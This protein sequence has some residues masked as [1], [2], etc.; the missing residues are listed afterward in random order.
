MFGHPDAIIF[1]RPFSWQCC[2]LCRPRVFLA[3]NKLGRFATIT[4]PC[5]LCAFE[6]DI[7]AAAA[8]DGGETAGSST[9]AGENGAKWYTVSGTC[10]QPGA[11]CL[12]PCGPCRRIVLQVSDGKDEERRAPVGAIARVVPGCLTSLVSQAS[13]YTISFPQG[14]HEHGLRR[15]SLTAAVMLMNYVF[16]EEK[17]N[18]NDGGGGGGGE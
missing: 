14:Q 12:C 4:N 11:F 1:N 13:S 6:F 2:C 16:A 18:K 7:H 5:R 15:A 3:H 17:K 9:V 8:E 10:C